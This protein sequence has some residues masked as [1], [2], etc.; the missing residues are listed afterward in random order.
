LDKIKQN[1]MH[2]WR[3][4][5]L[6]KINMK[7][8]G[9]NHIIKE[10]TSCIHDVMGRDKSCLVLGADVTHPS[11]ITGD[12]ISTPSIASVVGN[13]DDDAAAF[14]LIAVKAQKARTEI[15]V[16]FKECISRILS[17]RKQFQAKLPNRV[18]YI[19]DGVNEGQFE[20]VMRNEVD[21][22][23]A[24]YREL[25]EES[26]KITVIIV[27]KRHNVRFYNSDESMKHHNIPPG[28]II[29]KDLVHPGSVA[30]FWI[31]SHFGTIGTSH[32]ARYF[33][34]RDDANYGTER[35][36][37]FC[38]NMC[39]MF[40]RCTRAVSYPSPTYYAHLLAFR[41]KVLCADVL[42]GCNIVDENEIISRCNESIEKRL[43]SFKESMFYV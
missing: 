1:Q 19:R 12:R 38:Y 15:I 35:L 33:I 32:P 34:L 24:V 7:I 21:K 6:L 26:P 28:V 10:T 17:Q 5:L 2:Q 31:N 9:V 14:P 37:E 27:Q 39:H 13:I 23:D 22:I 29:K 36:S 4:N 8:G 43:P 16:E 18:M 41:G 42:D 30:N 20:A 40:G 11:K 25:S 3:G